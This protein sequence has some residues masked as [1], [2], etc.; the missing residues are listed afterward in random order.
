MSKM[1]Y[2]RILLGGLVAGIIMNVADAVTNGTIL[3]ARWAAEASALKP[4]LM[5]AM[6][7]S[8]TVGWI[9]VDF[10]T[11]ILMV[12]VYAAIRPRFGAG[13]RTALVAAIVMWLGTHLW[14]ESYVFMGLFTSS[15]IGVSSLGG[16][17][18]MLAGGYVGGM[19][20]KEG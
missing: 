11:A 13:P 4:D 12:W 7:A 3:A 17:V 5:T 16:L 1:N 15:L 14:Y 9:T 20:Y 2:S 18:G 8:S 19:L 6:A 10:L